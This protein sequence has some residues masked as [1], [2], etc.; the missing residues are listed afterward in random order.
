M[1]YLLIRW[2]VP[3]RLMELHYL[4]FNNTK[5]STLNSLRSDKK[6]IILHEGILLFGLAD[7][8]KYM[9]KEALESLAYGN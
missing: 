9:V 2:Q 6:K 7:Y 8:E 4:T 1:M 5:E 3:R